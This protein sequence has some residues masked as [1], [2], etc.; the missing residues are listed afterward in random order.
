[1]LKI[2]TSITKKTKAIML[3]HWEK[4]CDMDLILKI[5]KKHKIPIIE[6]HSRNGS[7]L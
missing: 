2:E 7:I 5:A 1:M 4:I 6:D 3:V